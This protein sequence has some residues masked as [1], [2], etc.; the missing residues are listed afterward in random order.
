[1]KTNQIK[2]YQSYLNSKND[3]FFEE[4][5]CIKYHSRKIEYRHKVYDI[6]VPEIWLDGD[7]DTPHMVILPDYLLLRMRYPIQV[8][9]YAINV[10][11]NDIRMSQR[12]AAQKTMQQF[13]LTTFAHTTLGRALKK[14]LAVIVDIEKASDMHETSDADG[15]IEDASAAV[16]AGGALEEYRERAKIFF[17]KW[18][19]VNEPARGGYES[20]C[21]AMSRRIWQLYQK[22]LI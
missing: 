11:C 3:G 2:K 5:Y 16:K 18:M 13:G 9:L 8:Y 7:K 20:A 14:L 1:L 21:R 17:D 22:F 15:A 10:Y 19:P 4:G 12:E 6:Q